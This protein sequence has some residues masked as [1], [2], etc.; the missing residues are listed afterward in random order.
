LIRENLYDDKITYIENLDKET[1]ISSENYKDNIHLVEIVTI[2]EMMSIKQE[3][4]ELLIKSEDA[5]PFQSWEWNY[6]FVSDFKPSE[7]LKIIAGY[8]KQNKLIGIAPM[9]ISS[10][11]ALGIKVLEFIGNGESDYLDF[12]VEE[13]YKSSFITILFNFL[14]ECNDWTM[15]NFLSIRE[16]TKKLIGEQICT[17]VTIETVCPFVILP[18]TMKEYEDIVHKRELNSVKR[19]LRKLLPQNRVAYMVSNSPENLKENMD[20]F[21]DLHQKRHNS[22][23]ERGIFHSKTRKE[24][25][26]KISK[27]MCEAGLLNMEFLKIDSTIAAANFILVLNKKKY[28]Y[29]SGMHPEFSQFKPGKLLIYYMI[30]HAIKNEYS[31]YDFLQGSEQ[32][33]YYW[34]NKEIKLYNIRYSRS[35]V[36]E[37][38]WK[39]YLS[40]KKTI[41][42]SNFLKKACGIIYASW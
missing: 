28:N 26:Y 5:T 33:K 27:L 30:E 1:S 41:Y 3:W 9:Q 20:Y 6:A 7:K 17:E 4:T 32:Y 24:R 12:L 29:L 34:T 19:Q 37:Y 8:N 35:R 15:L 22:K 42:N 38:I 40:L 14:E 11:F 31:V 18:S 36:L 39:R 21:V 23:G 25:F 2:V 16:N 10:R 13:E